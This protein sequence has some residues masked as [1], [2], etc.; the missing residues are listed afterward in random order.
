MVENIAKMK[1]L[2]TQTD[3][4][5][6]LVQSLKSMTKEYEA[7]LKQLEATKHAIQG[8]IAH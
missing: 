3:E 7:H 4:V 5:K 6:L 2:I 1:P 8:S